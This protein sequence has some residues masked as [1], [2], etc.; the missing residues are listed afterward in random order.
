MVTGAF[1][2]TLGVKPPNMK[3]VLMKRHKVVETTTSFFSAGNGE[4]VLVEFL[5][6]TRPK[7]MAPLMNAAYVRKEISLKLSLL[8][9]S[10][11]KH[12]NM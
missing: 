1:A 7:A 2:C 8:D 5:Y 11:L 6:Q 3:V 4:Y 9:L 10:H 12:S